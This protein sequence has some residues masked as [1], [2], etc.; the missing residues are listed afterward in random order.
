MISHSR[1]LSDS[2]KFAASARK[3]ASG[4]PLRQ[5]ILEAARE[6]F[7]KEGYDSVSM[8]RVGHQAGCS[9][10]AMYRYFASKEEL[11]ISVCEE[12][13]ADM[14]G[15]VAKAIAQQVSPIE[16]LRAAMRTYVEFGIH[17]PNHFKL[18][19]LTDIPS[20]PIALRKT[21]IIESG[22][23]GLRQLLE[24]CIESK[25]MS[26]DVELTVQAFHVTTEGLTAAYIT[27]PMVSR[28]GSQLIEHLIHVLTQ[29][30]E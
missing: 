8:R 28:H 12:T 19:Y 29:E 22:L 30:F 11:L 20:G 26:L 10:M 14:R 27:Q 15:E 2:S 1:S 9:A 17:H 4:V 6:L 21:A 5:Q 13:F 25:G 3:S 7:T 23:A 18:A 24:Q 16:K